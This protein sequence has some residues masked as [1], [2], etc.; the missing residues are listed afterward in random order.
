[1]GDWSAEAGQCSPWHRRVDLA[2]PWPDLSPPRLDPSSPWVGRRM[3]ARSTGGDAR[4]SGR[5]HGGCT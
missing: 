3:G 5:I 4:S 2:L 1:M